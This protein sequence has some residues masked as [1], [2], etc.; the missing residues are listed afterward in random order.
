M[1]GNVTISSGEDEASA[2]SAIN[3]ANTGV[4][5]NRRLHQLAKRKS[6]A[7]EEAAAEKAAKMMK[8]RL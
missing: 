6:A 4:V 8:K 2:A 7:R 3:L 5:N 1:C